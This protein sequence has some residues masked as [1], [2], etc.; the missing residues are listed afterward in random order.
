MNRNR[1]RAALRL[2][3][4]VDELDDMQQEAPRQRVLDVEHGVVPDLDGK[5]TGE[6][7]QLQL[8]MDSLLGRI[9]AVWRLRVQCARARTPRDAQ[10]AMELALERTIAWQVH[11]AHRIRV[12]RWQ[13]QEAKHG[14]R[15]GV[16]L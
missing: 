13:V 12:M 7:L 4:I 9:P 8:Y 10:Q 2:L 14:H 15:R 16:W 5:R 6:S 3:P 1:R 11:V